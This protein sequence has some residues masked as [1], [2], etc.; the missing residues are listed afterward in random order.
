M[1]SKWPQT[2]VFK[3]SGFSQG[4]RMPA[5]GQVLFIRAV[6]RTRVQWKRAVDTVQRTRCSGPLRALQGPQV[7]IGPSPMGA[8]PLAP[9]VPP[10]G[11]LRPMGL[12]WTPWGLGPLG[13]ILWPL[14]APWDHLGPK[15]AIAGAMY[16]N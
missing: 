14:G 11:P 13:A 9:H 10:M 8:G 4:R 15:Q 1:F 7:T 2:Q 3:I 12:L 6:Q 5:K 16:V